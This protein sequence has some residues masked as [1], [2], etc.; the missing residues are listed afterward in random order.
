MSLVTMNNGVV[1][2]VEAEGTGAFSY[3]GTCSTAAGTAAKIVTCSGFK[4]KVGA[5]IFVNFTSTNTASDCTLNVNSTGAIAIFTNFSSTLSGD[6][7]QPDLFNVTP[8]TANEPVHFFYNGTHWILDRSHMATQHTGG[9]IKQGEI[10][11]IRFS[12]VLNG[13]LNAYYG[14]TATAAS[15]ATKVVVCPEMTSLND[16][17]IL[18]CVFRNTNTAKAIKLNVNSIGAYDVC[19]PSNTSSYPYNFFTSS[20]VYAFIYV[21]LSERWYLC[22]ALRNI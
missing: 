19:G 3:Y 22:K 21:A 15:T 10:N 9:I 1:E 12:Q 5:H 14:Y 13:G 20:F 11:S 18:Y 16:G 17:D 8:L 6:P 7:T 2:T 4:L